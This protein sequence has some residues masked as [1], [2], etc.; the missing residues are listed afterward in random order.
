MAV[1]VQQSKDDAM[2]VPDPEFYSW[3]N[4]VV[5]LGTMTANPHVTGGFR[6]Q[7]VPTPKRAQIKKAWLTIVAKNTNINEVC[8]VRIKAEASDDP[9]EFGYGDQDIVSRTVGVEYADWVIPPIT[10]ENSYD[11]PDFANV[12][13]EVADRPGWHSGNSIVLLV[14]DNESDDNCVRATYSYDASASKAAVLHIVYGPPL[15]APAAIVS[16]HDDFVGFLMLAEFRTAH[17]ISRLLVH[18]PADKGPGSF[19][20]SI[21]ASDPQANRDTIRE[22]LVVAIRSSQVGVPPFVGRID[23]IEHDLA[24]GVVHVSGPAY[25]QLLF[26]RLLPQDCA[27]SSQAAGVIAMQL[28]RLANSSSPTGVW[29]SKLTEPGSPV[30]GDIDFGS[31]SLGDALND[32]A[33]RTGDEWWLEESVSRQKIELA[34]RWA[35]R[36]G[37]D[38][39]AEVALYEARHFTVAEY[40]QDSLGKGRSAVAVG[41]GESVSDRPAAAVTM[42]PTSVSGK[43]G[44]S[45]AASEIHNRNVAVGMTLA[46]ETAVFMPGDTDEAVLARAAQKALEVPASAAEELYLTLAPSAPWDLQ[47]GDIFRAVLPNANF[48]GVTRN[49]RLLDL[50]P[51]EA[52]GLRETAVKVEYDV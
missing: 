50:G 23:R 22:G 19:N 42:S 29:P 15:C 31:S 14:A 52:K 41:S 8:R 13:Q 2:Y 34:L 21:A 3:T 18:T 11:S 33:D 1:Q 7:T 46:R 36:R 30:R 9:L 39:R 25:A 49:V 16:T 43:A 45:G 28:L 12:I 44:V 35:R 17:D 6:F 26:E 10:I 4:T 51:D 32:L 37:R 38:R 48:G 24:A 5:D 20:F 40:T 27:F 47:P